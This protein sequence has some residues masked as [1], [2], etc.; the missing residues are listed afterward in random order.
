MRDGSSATRLLLVLICAGITVFA[1]YWFQS[2]HLS[3]LLLIALVLAGYGLGSTSTEPE[4]DTNS[5]TEHDI[6]LRKLRNVDHHFLSLAGEGCQEL[7]SLSKDIQSSIEFNSVQ[8][9]QSFH[10]LSESANAEKELMLG[11]AH[12]LTTAGDDEVSIKHFAD[13]VGSILDT[14]VELFVDISDKSVRAVHTIKDMVDHLDSMFVLIDGI[15]GIAEQTNLLALNAAIEAARA[16]EAG[17]GFAVVADEVRKLSQD[18]NRLNEEIRARAQQTKETVATVEAVVGEITSMDMSIAIDARGHLDGMLTELETVNQKAAEGVAQGA[19]IGESIQDDVIRAFASLQGADRVAQ[20]A[21]RMQTI[22]EF[23]ERVISIGENSS[24]D[25][26]SVSE[27]L[28][29]SIQRLESVKIPEPVTAA[30]DDDP[31]SDT[32]LF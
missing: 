12:S 24:R 8:L 29:L 19:K 17:R 16:G 28:E 13:E 10:S 1:H 18:S 9:H 26:S 4:I 6:A 5:D 27:A 20:Q 15:R 3:A 21:Y 14:Y 31:T 2:S 32:E 7:S 11:I 25:A 22:I 30:F 23:L